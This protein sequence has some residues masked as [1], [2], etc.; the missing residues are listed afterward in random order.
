MTEQTELMVYI[1][2]FAFTFFAASFLIARCTH[3]SPTEPFNFTLLVGV[4]LV[5]PLT[6]PLAVAIIL[7]LGI[8]SLAKRLAGR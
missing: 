2:V 6:V 1:A 3:E 8:A 7:L 5:W 4:S